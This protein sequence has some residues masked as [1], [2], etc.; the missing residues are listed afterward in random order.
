MKKLLKFT[1][2]L[3]TATFYLSGYAQDDNKQLSDFERYKLQQNKK[4]QAFKDQREAHIK[5]LEQDYKNYLAGLSALQ[6]EY[7]ENDEPE[8]AEIV[9][10]MIEYEKTVRKSAGKALREKDFEQPEKASEKQKNTSPN[11]GE[12]PTQKSKKPEELKKVES[13]KTQ[14]TEESP[15]RKETR[16]KTLK[17]KPELKADTALDSTAESFDPK[18][19]RLLPLPE[20]AS[21]I[22]SPFGPRMHPVLNKQLKHNGV[23]FGSPMNT[24]IYA[25]ADG[26]VTVAQYSKSFGNFIMIEHDQDYV[27]V[28]AHLESMDVKPCDTVK[29]GAKIALSGNTGRSTGPHLHYEIRLD[30]TPV[31]PDDYFTQTP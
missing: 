14:P 1:C 21:R 15:K 31:D 23:D 27:T 18:A 12:K 16:E 19:P 28:Y 30:G 17:D 6:K 10:D 9:A 22:T 13:P 8:N 4:F 26:K 7:E 5:R 29:Q 3:L 20:N 25:A 2:L 24:E 11:A